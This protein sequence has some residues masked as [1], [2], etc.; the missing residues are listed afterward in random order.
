MS[1]S[2][3]GPSSTFLGFQKGRLESFG[4]QTNKQTNKQV[5]V[6]RVGVARVPVDEGEGE[7]VEKNGKVEGA[8]HHDRDAFHPHHIAGLPWLVSKTELNGGGKR[9]R[10]CESDC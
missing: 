5:L 10:V 7:K 4:L 9:E 3:G 2:M 8:V 1:S 6:H